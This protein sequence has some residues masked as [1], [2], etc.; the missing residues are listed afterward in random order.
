VG[1][2]DHAIMENREINR[3]GVRHSDEGLRNILWDEGS[4]K[5]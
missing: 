1:Y 5:W 4:N 2:I 3:A